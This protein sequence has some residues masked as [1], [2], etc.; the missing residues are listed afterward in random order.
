MRSI[1]AGVAG[2]QVSCFTIP[3]PAPFAKEKREFTTEIT[4]DT[5]TRQKR[6]NPEQTEA[7]KASGPARLLLPLLLSV[8]SVI[9]VVNS[10]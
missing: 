9:S 2:R 10:S 8:S 5:E 3:D 4:E 7:R 6:R 1:P